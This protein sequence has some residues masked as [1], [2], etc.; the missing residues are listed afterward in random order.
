MRL[1]SHQLD[2]RL[3][4]G[5]V[6]TRVQT[7]APRSSASSPWAGPA[8]AP[9]RQCP[10]SCRPGRST[11]SCSAAASTRAASSAAAW[12]FDSFM[13][14]SHMCGFSTSSR[15]LRTFGNEPIA[16]AAAQNRRAQNRCPGPATA[17]SSTTPCGTCSCWPRTCRRGDPVLAGRREAATANVSSTGV[18]RQLL[19]GRRETATANAR[20]KRRG[21]TQNTQNT[22]GPRSSSPSSGTSSRCRRPRAR[23][24]ASPRGRSGR[25]P[26]R[27]PA[28][29]E[30]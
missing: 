11:A 30:Y 17:S 14:T 25:R 1:I 13:E 15:P 2:G 22:T 9:G 12:R 28:S 20:T 7:D 29:C 24:S 16:R 3:L 23:R 8:S 26:A 19:H 4:R 18:E 5:V 27:A 10:R 6:P 21:H